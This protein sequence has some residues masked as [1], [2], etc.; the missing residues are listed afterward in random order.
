MITKMSDREWLDCLESLGYT[1]QKNPNGIDCFDVYN[2]DNL[3]IWQY[4]GN[5]Q[6]EKLFYFFSGIVY[7]KQRF[8]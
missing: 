1:E 2:E 5:E 7:A 3:P 8:K 4:E 6:K